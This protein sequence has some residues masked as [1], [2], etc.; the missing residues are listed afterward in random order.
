VSTAGSLETVEEASGEQ[1]EWI[2]SRVSGSTDSCN[3]HATDGDKAARK[4]Y[5]GASAVLMERAKKL[6]WGKMASLR[7]RVKQ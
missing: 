1:E 4:R 2:L 7:K 5:H 3:T 6:S